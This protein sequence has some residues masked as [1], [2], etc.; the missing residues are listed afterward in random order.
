MNEVVPVACL[1]NYDA[2][3]KICENKENYSFCSKFGYNN[4]FHL[5]KALSHFQVVIRPDKDRICVVD[6]FDVHEEVK[7]MY[8]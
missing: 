4:V 6:C 5:N 2:I 8:L 3:I 1:S 7:S